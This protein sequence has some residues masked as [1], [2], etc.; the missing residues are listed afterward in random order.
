MWIRRSIEVWKCIGDKGIEWLTDYSIILL[1]T[2]KM[3]LKT[4]KMP[5]ECR[6]STLL[7]IYM[8][9]GDI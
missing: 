8:N 3:P 7:P 6:V 9:K 5:D 1:K 2:K 4:K